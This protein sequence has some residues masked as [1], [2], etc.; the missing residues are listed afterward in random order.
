M[1]SWKKLEDL[2]LLEVQKR[3]QIEIACLEYIIKKDFKSLSRFNVNGF[4]KILQREYEL[5]F[6]NFLEEYHA[7]LEEN[8][9]EK[10]NHVHISPRM[11]SY[12]KESSSVWYIVIIVVVLLI[13][14]L[15]WG[16]SRFFQSSTLDENTTN[17]LNQEQVVLEEKV[18]E[19]ETPV[20]NFFA[21]DAMENNE[22]NA[23]ILEPISENNNTEKT[24]EDNASSNM[25]EENI[26]LLNESIIKPSAELWLGMVDLKT[27]RKSSL[28]I[29]NDYVLPLDKD[30]LITTGHAAFS[31]NDENNN[32]LEFKN[33][34]SKFL[35]IKDG[36]IKQITKAEFIK[37]NRGKLW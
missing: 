23:T 26:I 13:V 20:L 1:D 31:L 5:D 19:N 18:D 27:F 21:D 22:T 14:A 33:G 9:I 8:G 17:V 7:Y 35:M 30:M 6:S 34:V 4:I 3:T 11:N 32:T 24:L 16:V 36:K 25:P 28:T 29:K 12:T 10:K 37:E 15:A 2:N